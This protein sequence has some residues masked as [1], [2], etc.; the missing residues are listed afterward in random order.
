M[1]EVSMLFEGVLFVVHIRSGLKVAWAASAFFTGC[2][3]TPASRRP[4][5]TIS[6]ISPPPSP[7]A[8][9]SSCPV[10]SIAVALLSISPSSAIHH[11]PLPRL[12]FN[13]AVVTE[14]ENMVWRFSGWFSVWFWVL[15]EVGSVV[16]W[17]SAV[18]GLVKILGCLGFLFF[19]ELLVSAASAFFTGCRR[20]PASRR[21]H[22]T[23]S[24]ISPPPSPSAT[25]SSCPVASI[26]AALLSISPSPAIRHGPLP[27]LSFN[28][29]VVTEVE[30]MVVILRLE[31]VAGGGYFW[32]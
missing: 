6:L 19:W 25:L 15:I 29:A 31:V 1:L 5:H 7:S 13:F 16:D 26:A 27:R 4:H 3:H 12:S 14:V 30:Y 24:L 2:R 32:V 18:E 23:I 9:L 20:T 21:P 22:H 10:A 11:G 8:T 28:F 17:I